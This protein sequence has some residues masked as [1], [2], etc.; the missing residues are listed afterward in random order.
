[1][2]QR[3]ITHP[4]QAAAVA[5]LFLVFRLIPLD[6]A[7]A[8]GGR[9]ARALGPRLPASR[10]ARRNLARAFPD[11]GPAEIGRIVAAMW[12][13]LGRVAAE[14]PHLGGLDPYDGSGRIEVVGAEVIDR[15][16]DDG[17]PGIFFSGHLGN[18]EALAISAARRGL[19]LTLV[20]R[21]P[22]N[23]LIDALVRRV[24]RGIAGGLVP[25]GAAGARRLVATLAAGGHLGL[26]VD[27]KMN[28]GIA[29]PFF[30]REAMTAPALVQLAL[31][32]DCPVVPARI[33]RLKGARFRI[34]L[35]PPLDLAKAG[36]R[37]ADILETMRR[38]NAVLEGW[39]R[40]RPEQWLWVHRRWPD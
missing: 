36:E 3:L 30:G 25:K 23:P 6:A 40:E 24:R 14:Y 11:K 17:R 18:W 22:D 8:L 33:E 27:Q 16:R 7:S 37:Q 39:I 29:V 28:D 2:V 19:P 32:F 26:L 31:R 20:F 35:F 34:T 9:L 1:M 21:A 15:L 38:V 13:N 10:I 5:L 12:E 4:L